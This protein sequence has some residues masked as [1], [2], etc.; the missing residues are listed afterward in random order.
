GIKNVGKA[1]VDLILAA[2]NLGGPFQSLHDFCERTQEQGAVTRATIEALIKCGAFSSIF[3]NRR[4]LMEAL[5][6]AL[7]TAMSAQRAR[8]AGQGE[9]FGGGA[10]EVRESHAPMMPSV[11]EYSLEE[12]L[13]FE[14]DLLGIYISDHPLE[15]YRGHILEN[16]TAS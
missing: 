1:A 9:L 8:E 10:S 5:D 14:K 13:A 6:N 15:K 12:I 16:A 2:R 4:A 3:L 11:P 7:R